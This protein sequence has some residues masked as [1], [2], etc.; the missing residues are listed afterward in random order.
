[1]CKIGARARL[2]LL[3]AAGAA[4]VQG[5]RGPISPTSLRQP[6]LQ[7][8]CVAGTLTPDTLVTG[9][10]DS[11]SACRALDLLSRESTFTHS[12][13]LPVQAGR[14]YLLDMWAQN[15]QNVFMKSR[16]ELVTAG[17][18]TEALL[19]ATRTSA[20]GR[21]QLVFVGAATD[22]DT[23]RA[24]T[25]DGAPSDTGA[26]QVFAET[27]KVPVPALMDSDSITHA[28]T[29]SAGDCQV[30]LSEFPVGD[31]NIGNAHL[32]ALHWTGGSQGRVISY[33]SDERLR[34]FIGGPHDD[35]GPPYPL[36][37]ATGQNRG[38]TQ[39]SREAATGDVR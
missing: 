35:T 19:A 13:V 24:T 33:T 12:Y 34:V 20:Y 1:M 38:L 17:A 9:D 29:I 14:G 21:A 36:K 27:C 18:S 26:Y 16:L 7:R 15:S 8:T 22:T 32:Y 3:A 28:D 23:V 10:L 37:L 31:G 30:D 6:T 25:V 11:A 4:V 2:T 39:V 5:C